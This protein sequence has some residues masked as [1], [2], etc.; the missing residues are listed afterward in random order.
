MSRWGALA[1]VAALALAMGAGCA[2]VQVATNFNGQAITTDAGG[3]VA[4]VNVSNWGFYFL[5][6]Y[7]LLTGDTV[8]QGNIA[9]GKDTVTVASAIEML[10]VA[11]KAMGATKTT[12]ITSFRR[13]IAVLP[14]IIWFKTVQVS[15]NATR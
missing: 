13:S 2:T 1:A 8:T 10:T 14:P 9:V 6:S 12:D 4:H 3:A 5:P 11:T 7:A 15:G